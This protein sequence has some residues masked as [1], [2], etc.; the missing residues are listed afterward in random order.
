[1]IVETHSRFSVL[2]G[3][4]QIARVARWQAKPKDGSRARDGRAAMIVRRNQNQQ[5][6]RS[7]PVFLLIRSAPL[8]DE[9]LNTPFSKKDE[10]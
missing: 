7:N 3:G 8:G 4:F 9:S 6:S 1:V 5:F 2:A 10:M